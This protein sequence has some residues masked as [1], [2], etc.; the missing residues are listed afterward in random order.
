MLVLE[1]S[2]LFLSIEFGR[3]ERLAV[4]AAVDKH[5]VKGKTKPNEN[6]MRRDAE[7][8]ASAAHAERTRYGSFVCCESNR[9]NSNCD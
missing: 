8:L 2:E 9:I 6:K 7:R 5:V 3:F 4:A 1:G